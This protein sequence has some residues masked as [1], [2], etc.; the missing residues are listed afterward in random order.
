MLGFGSSHGQSCRNDASVWPPWIDRRCKLAGT[1]PEVTS[2]A[3]QCE[4]CT[5]IG[6]AASLALDP[7]PGP[8]A[9]SIFKQFGY[10]IVSGKKFVS[11]AWS[12][13]DL[14]DSSKYVLGSFT[15]NDPGVVPYRAT[16]FFCLKRKLGAS[17]LLILTYQKEGEEAKILAPR[18]M[19]KRSS[20]GSWSHWAEF[21]RA[22][23]THA[24]KASNIPP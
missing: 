19:S 6:A 11:W 15:G 7:D 17:N 21:N 22:F 13:Y 2:F 14:I 9:L 1:T 24:Y 12:G 8:R 16:C 20:S 18:H 10:W 5:C 23:T 4:A 3:W